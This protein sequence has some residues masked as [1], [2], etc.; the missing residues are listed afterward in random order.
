M[1]DLEFKH[2][3]V[4]PAEEEDVVIRAGLPEVPEDNP[5]E[6][7][8]QVEGEVEGEDAPGQESAPPADEPPAE[9][10]VADEPD[11]EAPPAEAPAGRTRTKKADDYHE[12]T[13]A[14]LDSGPM[15]MA[16]RIVIIAAVICIIGAL[17]YYFAFMG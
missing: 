10:P 17:A 14:D 6:A 16:Q 1:G 8:I 11:A 7:G 12:T 2:I 5:A 3:S 13:L 4:T 15:P 9:A